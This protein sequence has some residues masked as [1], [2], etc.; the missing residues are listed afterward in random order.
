MTTKIGLQLDIFRYSDI[1]SQLSFCVVVGLS[2]MLL[3]VF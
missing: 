1:N 3:E 2:P